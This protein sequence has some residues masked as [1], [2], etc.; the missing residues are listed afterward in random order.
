MRRGEKF[1]GAALRAGTYRLWRQLVSDGSKRSIHV[2][3]WQ[4]SERLFAHINLSCQIPRH[5]REPVRKYRWAVPRDAG[6][7]R[8]TC[9]EY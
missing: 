1:F 6:Q 9:V 8:S 5:S 3:L 2:F 4:R 7:V